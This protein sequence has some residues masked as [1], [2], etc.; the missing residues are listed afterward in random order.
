MKGDW[1]C[2]TKN[3][4]ELIALIRE[5]DKPELVASYMLSL[6]LDY[7]HTHGPCQEKPSADPQESA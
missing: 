1:D 3:E 4:E 2:M 5:N 6:F 7:L